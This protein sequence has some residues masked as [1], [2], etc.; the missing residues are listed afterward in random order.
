MQPRLLKLDIT[1]IE[2]ESTVKAGQFQFNSDFTE[3]NIVHIVI[4]TFQEQEFTI[5]Q[6]WNRSIRLEWTE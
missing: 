4:K 2:E 1:I 3:E 5:R 6:G